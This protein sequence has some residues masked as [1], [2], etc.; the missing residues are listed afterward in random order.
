MPA[1]SVILPVYNVEEPKVPLVLSRSRNLFKLFMS[2]VGLLAKQY[3]NGIQLRIINGDDA[4]NYGAVF[5]NFIAQELHAHSF[6]LYYFNSKKQGE[7]DFLI[8]KD[9]VVL[10]IEVKSGKDYER[11]RALRNVLSNQDY[12]IDNAIV[13]CNSNV[14]VETNICYL[15]MYMAMFLKKDN[16]QSLKYSIDLTG[17]N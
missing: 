5:E 17:L 8:E 2:D 7:I 6:P 10:P 14:S 3:A 4:V 15:P 11:H 12:N 13:F 9:G 16:I 1:I